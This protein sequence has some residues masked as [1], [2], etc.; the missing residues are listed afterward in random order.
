MNG[1]RS[2]APSSKCQLTLTG[3][4]GSLSDG[5]A[6]NVKLVPGTPDGAEELTLRLGACGSKAP[7]EQVL[8]R[9]SPR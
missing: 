1:V 8:P 6:V 9:G 7:I 2:L 3:S 4:V 5:V